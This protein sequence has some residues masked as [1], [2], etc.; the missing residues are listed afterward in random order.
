MQRFLTLVS[1]L[2]LVGLLLLPAVWTW[3]GE[4]QWLLA[5][6][7]YSPAM[8]YLVPPAVLALAALLLKSPTPRLPLLASLVVVY[9]LYADP[10][11]SLATHAPGK[12]R[13]LSYNILG[14]RLD[15]GG[16]IG[17]F[18]HR[19]DCDLILL[20]EAYRPPY[21]EDPIPAIQRALP[22]YHMVR[23]GDFGE[24]AI[25]S[26]TPIRK[27]Q[28]FSLACRRPALWAEVELEGRP[29]RVLN[30]HYDHFDKVRTR[31]VRT[32][33]RATAR[34]R[35]RQT[36]LLEQE[37]ARWNGP[38]ILA[39]DFNSPPG[40]DTPTR[41]REKLQDAYACVGRGL[42]QSFPSFFPLWRI[43]YVYASRHFQVCRCAPLPVTL[44][45]HRPIRAELN[46]D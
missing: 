26:R 39:G 20:Q 44:S 24:L 35:A 31:K 27:S 33:L 10:V 46:L 28:E 17:S 43:D 40:S 29:V 41:L 38:V 25:F 37:L 18:L 1:W 42:G 4:R 22:G 32:L 23:G 3:K 13:V 15:H 21:G 11:V 36:D 2:Y 45:D 34:A 16:Q 6:L 5:L 30:V 8:A 7:R 19:Q 12:L 9:A 14:G